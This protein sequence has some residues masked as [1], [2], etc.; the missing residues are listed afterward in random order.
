MSC[1]PCFPYN[2]GIR[3]SL[4]VLLLTGKLC[5]LEEFLNW[6]YFLQNGEAQFGLERVI[7]FDEIKRVPN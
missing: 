1:K 5:I 6:S 2:T 3:R 4:Q 7:Y